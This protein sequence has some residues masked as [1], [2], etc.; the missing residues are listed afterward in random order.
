MPLRRTIAAQTQAVT[1]TPVPAVLVRRKLAT[2][3][4]RKV[5]GARQLGVLG[6]FQQN[7]G[8]EPR[9]LR[10]AGTNAVKSAITIPKATLC[11]LFSESF[12]EPVVWRAL[13]VVSTA[14]VSII[15]P[16]PDAVVFLP[17]PERG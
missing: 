5:M 12:S 2:I 17:D 6:R 13:L 7:V 16:D 9:A 11:S 4:M 1:T 14:A 15:L 8:A 3:Q 10:V